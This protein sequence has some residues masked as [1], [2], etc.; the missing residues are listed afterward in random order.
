MRIVESGQAGRAKRAAVGMIAAIAIQ[1]GRDAAGIDNIIHD[2]RTLTA[3]AGTGNE[4]GASAALIH[5]ITL[6]FFLEDTTKTDQKQH[7]G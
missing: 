2:N 5:D 1:D 7:G 4:N 3:V 6:S